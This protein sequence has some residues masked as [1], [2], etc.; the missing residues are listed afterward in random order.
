M[1]E[2]PQVISSLTDL[3]SQSVNHKFSF[4]AQE[5]FKKV[6]EQQAVLDYVLIKP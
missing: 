3:L 5:S 6:C 1:Q 2:K 4:T